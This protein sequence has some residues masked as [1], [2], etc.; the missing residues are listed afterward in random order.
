MTLIIVEQVN[1]I[2]HQIKI[3]NYNSIL[4][5]KINKV[6]IIAL[7]SNILLRI[8]NNNLFKTQQIKV[9][10]NKRKQMYCQG[11]ECS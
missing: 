8:I 2:I 7:A 5:D 3:E 6:Y 1:Q 4:F 9:D 10:R 11:L